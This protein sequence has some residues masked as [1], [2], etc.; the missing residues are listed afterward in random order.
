MQTNEVHS[1][2]FQFPVRAEL[3]DFEARVKVC[4][5]NE[6]LAIVCDVTERKR[7]EEEVLE[8]S[9]RERRRFGHDLH[10][11]LGQYLA[12]VAVK[13]ALLKED[14]AAASSPHQPAA[15]ELVRLIKPA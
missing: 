5:A 3:R 10:D 2:E 6:V 9:A 14:L 12:G 1:F 4:G 13:A 15:K 11:G 7:L 8:I